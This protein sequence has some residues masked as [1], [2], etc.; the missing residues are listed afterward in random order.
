MNDQADDPN[1]YDELIGL[2][3]PVFEKHPQMPMESRA[4]QFLPFAA[5]TGY[6]AAIQETARLTDTRLDL[7]E[8]DKL[9]LS[10]KLQLIQ[11][12]IRAR[13]EVAIT[14]FVPDERKTGG[15]YRVV[16]GCV[17]KV[18]AVERVILFTDSRR[19]M[20]DDVYAIDGT[21]FRGMDERLG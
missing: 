11:D 1:R 12:Q 5:L 4:A 6:D 21:L 14:H 2:P 18:D 17:K 13:P 20:I 16:R 10:S 3:H 15:A 19:I 8:D 7:D 9:L